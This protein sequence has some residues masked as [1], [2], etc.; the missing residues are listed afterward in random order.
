MS[1]DKDTALEKALG[2]L[3]TKHGENFQMKPG[4]IG[5]VGSGKLTRVEFK[6]GATNMD[7][8]KES[9][10]AANRIKNSINKKKYTQS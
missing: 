1:E 6:P 4:S 7:P 10:A 9:E 5:L 3:A 8:E 2:A